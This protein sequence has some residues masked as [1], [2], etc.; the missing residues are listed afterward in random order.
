M[1]TWDR[2]FRKKS[3][4]KKSKSTKCHNLSENVL[5]WVQKNDRG[6]SRG[7][8]GSKF[9][10]ESIGRLPGIPKPFKKFKKGQK[11]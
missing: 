7:H 10:C 4:F 5:K 3:D 8:G 6:V 9:G 11:P 2:L 1:A